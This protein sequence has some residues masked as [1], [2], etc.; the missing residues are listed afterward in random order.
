MPHHPH[1][2]SQSP[3]ITRHKLGIVPSRVRG[4]EY[5]CLGH[6]VSL[7]RFLSS[8]LFVI[9]VCPPCGSVAHVLRLWTVNSAA[10]WVGAE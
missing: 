10:R 4:G 8:V 2:S 3:G 5:I 9:V 1:R 6:G 7:G